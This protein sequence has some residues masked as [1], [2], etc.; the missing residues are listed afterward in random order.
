MIFY[1][2]YEK[3]K[4]KTIMCIENEINKLGSQERDLFDCVPSNK[5]IIGVKKGKAFDL[6]VTEGRGLLFDLWLKDKPNATNE[7]GKKFAEELIHISHTN[8]QAAKPHISKTE[9]DT[10]KRIREFLPIDIARNYPRAVRDFLLRI[11]IGRR[12]LLVLRPQDDMDVSE[13]HQELLVF[14]KGFESSEKL[15]DDYDVLEAII[16]EFL[17]KRKSVFD[18]EMFLKNTA[19]LNLYRNEFPKAG[20]LVGNSKKAKRLRAFLGED[21]GID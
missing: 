4:L 10:I 20:R 1:G 8:H 12:T 5:K 2:K 19:A 9:K 7:Y 21:S 18:Q 11:A 14:I 17:E 15:I 6:V 13:A 3:L 16:K